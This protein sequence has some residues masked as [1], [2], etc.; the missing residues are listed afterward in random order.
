MFFLICIL[1]LFPYLSSRHIS[2]LVCFWRMK[3]KKY[4]VRSYVLSLV[5]LHLHLVAARVITTLIKALFSHPWVTFVFY[6]FF[7]KSPPRTHTSL[8]HKSS[9]WFNLCFTLAF[10]QLKT[11]TRTMVKTHSC[12]LIVLCSEKSLYVWLFGG[13]S[14][15][16]L[17]E[18]R[19]FFLQRSQ[20]RLGPF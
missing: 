5:C 10:A 15:C 14:F 4:W 19:T 2:S 12:G 20:G 7:R 16:A 1:F 11:G 17:K 3:N 9:P 6:F 8:P 18:P 13:I